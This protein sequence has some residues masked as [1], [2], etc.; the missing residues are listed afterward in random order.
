MGGLTP[1]IVDIDP[2][3]WT[4]DPAE[5]ER[6]L[7]RHGERIGVVVPYATFGTVIDL[8]RYAWLAQRYGVGIV[9]D[10]A[11]SLGT[12][13]EAGRGFG[14]GRRSRWSIRCTR[15]RPFRSERAA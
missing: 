6:M 5:E 4:A 7:A 11:A 3:D 9:I 12:L 10:A 1:L 2:R 15:P 14:A 13:D 8:D